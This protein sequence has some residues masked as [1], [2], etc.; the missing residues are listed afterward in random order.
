MSE[1]FPF[2]GAASDTGRVRRDNQDSYWVPPRDYDPALLESK[3]YLCVV[4]D[5]MGGHAQ[6]QVASAMAVARVVEAYYRDRDNDILRVLERAVYLANDAVYVAGK[7]TEYKGMGTTLVAVVLKGNRAMIAN[8]GD[9]RAYLIS[10]GSAQQITTDHSEVQELVA[11]GVLTPEQAEVYPHRNII[12]RAIGVFAE[13]LPDLFEIELNS[14][15]AIL[16]CSD[17]LSNPVDELALADAVTNYTP[18]DAARELV[19]LANA[20]GGT[21][22]IT[23]VVVNC[24]ES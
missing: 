9:S 22:N 13:M 18:M 8:V 15:A 3:G 19:N 2:I 7:K 20:R 4:A 10:Q 6:G 11:Q 12:T 1:T 5:G 16:L 21:D 14:G 24:M 23:A 17:G